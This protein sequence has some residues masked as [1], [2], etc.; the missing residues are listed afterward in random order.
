MGQFQLLLGQLSLLQRIWI[1][2]ATFGSIALLAVFVSVAGKPNLQAAFSGLSA[3][4][5]AAVTEALR[6]AKVNFE[7]TDAGST[8]MVS[9]TALS[10]ARVAIGAAGLLPDSKQPGFELFDKGGF[11]MSQFEQ[12]VTL[13]RATEGQLSQTIESLGGVESAR[14]SI[15]PAQD[16]LLASQNHPA[17]ASV[18]VAMRNGQSPDR[19]LVR[20]IVNTVAGSVAGLSSDNVTVV[21]NQG[22]VLAGGSDSGG[23]DAAATQAGVERAIAAKV[24]TLIEQAIGAGHASVAVS[25]TMDFA[26]VQQQITTYQPVTSQNWTPV[27]VHTVVESLAGNPAGAGLGGGIPGSQS[28]LPGVPSYLLAA[29]PD[30]SASPGASGSPEPSASP[31]PSDSPSPSPSASPGASPSASPSAS[32][33]AKPNAS[34]GASPSPTSGYGR[35]EETVNY[36]LNQTIETVVREPGL[37][38]RLSVAVLLDQSVAAS[39]SSETLQAQIEAAVG[40]DK[41]RGD[42][43]T[44]ASIPFATPEPTKDAGIAGGLASAISGG[45]SSGTTVGLSGIVGTLFG[46]IL[47]VALLFLVWRNMR[48]LDRRAEEV[49]LLAEPPGRARLGSGTSGRMLGAGLADAYGAAGSG[50]PSAQE[51]IQDRLRTVADQK[52]EALVGLMNGWLREDGA[53]R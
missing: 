35:T 53:R 40:A 37:L 44:V 12:Q 52:P 8:I 18:V 21:D 9:S 39:I 38:T 10:D 29:S 51:L 36:N 42:V 22:N 32:A 45:G 3:S 4:D 17:S 50:E 7:L 30:P 33:S 27:S 48:A 19:A 34:A 14:V 43:V 16:G 25:A 1:A 24:T 11:G 49:S 23:S 6:K 5:A 46:T 15:V 31:A 47:A 26:K 20:G 41:A 28:N 13:Q 2:A